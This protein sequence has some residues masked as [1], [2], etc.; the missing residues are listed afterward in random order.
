MNLSAL[1]RFRSL[2]AQS[3]LLFCVAL[4]VRLAIAVLQHAWIHPTQAEMG[5]EAISLAHSGILGNP[6]G[7]PTGPSAHVNP[8][9]AAVLALIFYLFGTEA[10]GE[11]VKVALTCLITS[12]QYALCP[13][14]GRELRLPPPIAFGAGLFGA[15][16]PLNPY[17]ETRG[18]FENH[19]NALL[20]L[21]LIIWT[22][23]L[24][25]VV[26]T[27]KEA[28]AFGVFCGASVLTSSVLLPLDTLA[29]V[30]IAYQQTRIPEG[31]PAAALLSV[32]M[33]ILCLAPW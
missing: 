13:A 29:I 28:I 22:A 27:R 10:V 3:V 23:R 33:V 2:R 30:Y 16:V 5:R 19:V 11:S 24:S 7:V 14:L 26:W 15:L 8:G 31:S 9:Y 18:D 12:A 17:V 25:R 20:L 1:A 4:A 21:L 6:F 32:L